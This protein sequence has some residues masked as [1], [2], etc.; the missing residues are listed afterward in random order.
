LLGNADLAIRQSENEV[1]LFSS[2]AGLETLRRYASNETEPLRLILKAFSS[3]P[4]F[5]NYTESAGDGL[6]RFETKAL[7]NRDEPLCLHQ[8]EYA[9]ESDNIDT[10]SAV[11]MDLLEPSERLVKPIF[12]AVLSLSADHLVPR[13]GERFRAHRYLVRF[14]ARETIWKYYLLGDLCREGLTMKGPSGQTDFV[15]MGRERLS[16]EEPAC[17][18]RSAAAIP[19]RERSDM[20]VQLLGGDER[21]S[22][23]VLVKRLPV[24]SCTQLG[25]VR[26]DETEVLVSEI[27]VNS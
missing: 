15:F 10:E 19:L 13:D 20:R 23:K 11:A 7:T 26:I 21:G 12:V 22:N 8:G 3:D 24:A 27:Y 18:F 25:L 16:N 14:K 17:I 5:G 4:C 1:G 6:F 9:S 2:T